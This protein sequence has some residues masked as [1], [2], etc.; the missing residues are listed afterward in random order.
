MRLRLAELQKSD[1]EARK[2]RTEDLNRYEEHDGL[3][4]HQ[5]LPFIPVV[6]RTEIIS[7]YH[8]DPLTGHFSI[9]KTK[10]LVGRKYY[11]PSLRRDIE[12]YVKGCDICLASKTVRYK[13]YGDLESLLVSTHQWKDLSMDFVFG[14]PIS[15][16]L[17]GNNDDSILVIV[18]RLTKM[19]YYELVKVT[20]DA[21]GLAEVMLDVVVWHYGLPDSIVSDRGSLFTSKFPSSLCYFLG[22]KRR[23]SIAF[24]SQTNGQTE[25]QN[26]TIEVYLQAFVNFE[27]NDWAKLV[28]MAEFAY[29]KAKNASTGQ[30]PFEL[31]C[32][33][34][35]RMSYEENVDPCSKSKSADKLS[36]KLKELMIVAGRTSTMPKNFKNGPMTRALRLEAMLPVTK[37]G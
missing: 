34:H 35:P 7:Q 17:T 30:T 5:G 18:D 2:I 24:Y 4:Y 23:L 3:L 10:N 21:L 8:D 28:P 31:N 26:S 1:Q 11:W 15:T 16:D 37:S 32:G 27:Q 33:Y 29:N 9:N 14:L 36:V 20:I 6:I 13:H 25:R 19:V 12:A 22:I